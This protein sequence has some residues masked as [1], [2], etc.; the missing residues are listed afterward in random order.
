MQNV[1]IQT[2]D[3]LKAAGHF[4]A[5]GALTAEMGYGP[6]YG[7]HFGM[8]SDRARAMRLFQAGYEAAQAAIRV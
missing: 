7:C 6:Q 3:A 4:Y 2:I 5:A 1:T 8:R